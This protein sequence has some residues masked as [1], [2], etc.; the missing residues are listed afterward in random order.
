MN[1]NEIN[2]SF[3]SKTYCGGQLTQV[4]EKVLTPLS[5]QIWIK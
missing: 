2:M 3:F 1:F 5:S 4:I